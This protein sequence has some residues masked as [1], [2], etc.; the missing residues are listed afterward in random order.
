MYRG[1]GLDRHPELRDD[2]FG[3]YRR[4]VWLAQHRTPELER[5]RAGRGGQARPGAEIREVGE[6]AARRRRS[7]IRA[8]RRRD[9]VSV[10]HEGP[11]RC[12]ARP[13]RAATS[14]PSRL[15]GRPVPPATGGPAR[16]RV[17]SPLVLPEHVDTLILGGGTTGAVIAGLL[18]ERSDETV[19]VLEAG[20]D[21]GPLAGGRWPRAL[22]T[23]PCSASASTTGASR[24]ASR[25]TG[26]RST[27]SGLA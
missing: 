14:G 4:V 9:L 16:P 6:A 10:W 22:S 12:L 3:N 20:P 18:A 17:R 8:R 1:L 13:T 21:Y 19:L 27:S 11:R 5:G 7:P 26:A 25:A 24:P 23:P 2:Y 15:L